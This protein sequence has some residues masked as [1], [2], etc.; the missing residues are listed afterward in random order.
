MGR[1]REDN[2]LVAPGED[3]R[4][5]TLVAVASWVTVRPVSLRALRLLSF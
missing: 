3:G 1:G 2:P 4:V 5:T